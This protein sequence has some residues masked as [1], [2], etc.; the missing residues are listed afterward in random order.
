MPVV[1]KMSVRHL[2]G[3]RLV[4]GLSLAF[5]ASAQTIDEYQVKA[6]FLYNFAKFVEWPPL[7]FKTDKDPMRICVLGQN[8]FG[9]ALDEAV[10]GQNVLGRPFVVTDVQD[11]SHMP[12]CQILFVAASERKRL[13]SIFAEL[14]TVA[15]LTVGETDGFATQG[16]IVNFKLTDGHVRLEINVEAAGLAK[17]RINSRVLSLAQIVKTGMK[18]P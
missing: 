14:R 9:G 1:K 15:I 7:T 10:G 17:L 16:G 6:E 3:C 2:P 11:S 8:P 12:D 4:L 18:T 13:R 5:I